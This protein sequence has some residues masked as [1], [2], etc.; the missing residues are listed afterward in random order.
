MKLTETYLYRFII[1]ILTTRTDRV[2]V[3]TG[4]YELGDSISFA[5]AFIQ[6]VNYL[7]INTW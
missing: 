7:F 2:K 4:L 3:S 5:H 6:T 1:K